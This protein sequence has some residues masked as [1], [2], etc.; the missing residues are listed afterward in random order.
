MFVWKGIWKG[1]SL[2]MFF[3]LS[4][5][6]EYVLYIKLVKIAEYLPS[7]CIAYENNMSYFDRF[8][9]HYVVTFLL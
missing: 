6:F 1:K 9:I 4:I 5:W 8:I 2:S 3:R 7:V